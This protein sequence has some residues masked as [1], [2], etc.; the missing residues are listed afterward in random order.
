MLYE[1]VHKMEFLMGVKEKET[2]G[3]HLVME[4]KVGMAEWQRESETERQVFTGQA[5]INM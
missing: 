1:K 2:L 5:N 3:D 4:P